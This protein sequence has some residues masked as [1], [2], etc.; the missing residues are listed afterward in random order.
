MKKI[1]ITN[2]LLFIVAFA[3]CEAYAMYKYYYIM[4][5]DWMERSKYY[6]HEVNMMYK[7]PK[8]FDANN[9]PYNAPEKNRVFIK[10]SQKRPI[11]FV[12]CSFTEGGGLKTEETFAY[13]ISRLTN[14]TVYLKGISGTGF[15]YVYYQI[16]N[17]LIPKDVEYIIYTYIE[18]HHTRLYK[19]QIFMEN[20][21]MNLRYK[22]DKNGK[23]EQIHNHF[24]FINALYITK[25]FQENISENR[26]QKE[27]RDSKLF[28]A[29]MTDLMLQMK[30][31]YPA[32]KFV[33]LAYPQNNSEREKISPKFEN[34]IKSLDC[35]YL[36]AEELSGENLGSQEWKIKGEGAHPSTEAW[37]K[38]APNFI[39]ALNL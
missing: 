2:I 1:I 3:L 18:D 36:N 24:N 6:G 33:F 39:K 30:K 19:Y 13:K 20:P 15:S 37:D 5:A 4:F 7:I 10:N 9:G 17:K 21:Q 22:I 8:E 25:L 34:F 23:L 26:A 12:G 16:A 14:R 38:V 32:T 11:C 28:R 35:V 29:M 27:K 31:N